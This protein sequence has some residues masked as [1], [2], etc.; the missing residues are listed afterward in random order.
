[1]IKT[2]SLRSVSIV[3]CGKH[4][5]F[6]F[7]R[8]CDLYISSRFKEDLKKA[9]SLG[10]VTYILSAKHG[11]LGVDERVFT[12]DRSLRDLKEVEYKNWLTRVLT[13]VE[14]KII[15][16]SEIHFFCFP[17]YIKDLVPLLKVEYKV[18]IQLIRLVLTSS[19]KPRKGF[20]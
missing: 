7:Y 1:M 6:G 20:S 10:S 19:T 15:L 2:D 11:L 3:C 4:K 18:V 9:Q 13:S 12:Y 5:K 8:A 17:E 16:G 14:E